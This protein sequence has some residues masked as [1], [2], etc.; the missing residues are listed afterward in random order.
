MP[1]ARVVGVVAVLSF[2]LLAACSDDPEPAPSASG[3]GT[4]ASSPGAS[5]STAS[6]SAGP[7]TGPS[8][9]P[10]GSPS[11]SG[12]VTAGPP[13][14]GTGGADSGDGTEAGGGTGATADTPGGA[15]VD[16]L[17]AM[18][19]SGSTASDGVTGT[20]SARIVRSIAGYRGFFGDA[21]ATVD[22]GQTGD[23]FAYARGATVRSL[24]VP[25]AGTYAYSWRARYHVSGYRPGRDPSDTTVHA[26]SYVDPGLFGDRGRVVAADVDLGT[27][28]DLPVDG[29]LSGS[30][31]VTVEA[32]Q[33]V[34]VRVESSCTIYGSGAATRATCRS[35]VG[36]TSFTLKRIG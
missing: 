9:S 20:A 24:T 21:R 30:G 12:S 15:R 8:A 18:R 7:T 27:G 25:A 29:T 10:G 5:P 2:G 17:G 19:D 23:S 4:V 6:P 1:A 11:P 34:D 33:Q 32:G 16:V 31:E 14:T 22:A 28:V 35:W 13:G 26:E 3:S 36:F